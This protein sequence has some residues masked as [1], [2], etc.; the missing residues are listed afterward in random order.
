VFDKPDP[1]TGPTFEETLYVTPSRHDGAQRG[2]AER[3]AAAMASALGLTDG[4]VHAEV[5]LDDRGAWPIE[6][7]ARSIGGLCS[8]ALRF[9]GG[10]TLEELLLRHALGEDVAGREREAAA[11]GVMM[12]PIPRA[13]ILHHVSGIEEARAIPGIEDVRITIPPG[14]PVLPPPEGTRYLGF[15]FARG[16]AAGDVERSLRRAHERLQFEIHTE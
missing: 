2:A 4:P 11:S 9:A 5:R 10:V 13:G 8:R 15:L 16:D 12:V 1:L 3:I 6:I 7:A 14:S